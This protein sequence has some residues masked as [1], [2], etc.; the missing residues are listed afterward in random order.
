MRQKAV[1]NAGGKARGT[2]SRGFSLLHM[3]R[4]LDHQRDIGWQF[5]GPENI[6]FG[7]T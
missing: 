7:V 3:W 1:L 6:K 2:G 4:F 5:L